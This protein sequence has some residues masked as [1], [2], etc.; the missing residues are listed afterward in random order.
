MTVARSIGEKVGEGGAEEATQTDLAVEVQV[1]LADFEG[2]GASISIATS[3]LRLAQ[4]GGAFSQWK[5]QLP[6]VYK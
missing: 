2:P 1:G 6:E 3:A 4:R 5:D